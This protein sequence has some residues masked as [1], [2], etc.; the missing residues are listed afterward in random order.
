MSGCREKQLL[1]APSNLLKQGLGGDTPWLAAHH[2]DS[3]SFYGENETNLEPDVQ[4][5]QESTQCKGSLRAQ[6]HIPEEPPSVV[7]HEFFL[8]N[9]EVPKP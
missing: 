3:P 6:F 8:I 2:N 9:C 5:E 7:S 4:V 1:K